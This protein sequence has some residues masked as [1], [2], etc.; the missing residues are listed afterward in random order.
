[1]S[2]NI[3]K[4][5]AIKA[6]LIRHLETARKMAQDRRLSSEYKVM[7]LE[8]DIKRVDNGKEPSYSPERWGE[9]LA[10]FPD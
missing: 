8:D 4:K 3:P 10:Q 6:E 7:Y 1:M 9:I 2:N 5:L